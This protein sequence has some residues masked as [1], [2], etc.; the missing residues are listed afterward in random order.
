LTDG[1]LLIA[2]GVARD[3]AALR[4]AESWN[5]RAGNL[6]PAT[7]DLATARRNH[8]AQLLADGKMLLCGGTGDAGQLLQSCDLYDPEART[9]SLIDTVP[10]ESPG[11]EEG[12]H[13]VASIPDDGATNVATDGQIALRFSQPLNVATV[14]PK[15]VTLQGPESSLT[16]KAIPAEGGMLAFVS[17]K[18]SLLP[19]T[20]YVLSLDGL[21]DAA[22]RSLPSTQI[23][24]RTAGPAMPIPPDN[25][26]WVPDG[27]SRTGR[28]DSPWE[29]LPPLKAPAGTTAIAGRALKLNG[30][31]LPDV[32]LELDQSAYSTR[33]DS[34]GRFLLTVGVGVSG[35]CVL[36]IQGATANRPGKTY[37]LFQYGV[38][39][40]AGITTVLP[41]TIWMPLLDT[42]HA[43][44]IPSPT[45]K[46]TTISTPLLPGLALR[47]PPGTVVYDHDG[48]VARTI[49]ITPIPLDRPP[50]PLPNVPVPIYFTIQPGGAQLK[51]LNPKGPQGAQ[52]VYPNTYNSPVGTVYQFWNYEADG[53]GWYTYGLGKVS[54]DRRSIVPDPG[55]LIYEFTGAMV[56]DAGVPANGPAAGN[57]N[58][59]CCEPV[60]L[61][62]GLF[63][64]TKTD[65]ALPDIIP[66]VLTRTY[67]PNDPTTRAFGVGATHPYDIFLS[68]PNSDKDIYLILPDGGRIHFSNGTCTS[69]PT[70]FYGATVTDLGY[71]WVVKKKDGTTLTFPISAGASTPQQEAI[72]GYQDRYGNSLRF[73]RDSNSNLIGITSPNGRFIE[74]TLDSSGRIT[75][76]KDNIGRTV[77]Y[78]YDSCAAGL[79]CS[80]TDA[81][82]GV[83]SYTYD[84]SGNM[85]TITDPRGITYLTNQYDSNNRVIKQTQA[86]NS[87][88]QLSYTLD[89]NNN[90]TQAT[91]TDP[92]G[93]KRTT[94]FDS[95]GYT[96]SD[97]LAVGTAQ[98]EL[99]TFTRSSTTE[100]ISDVIDP[101][102]RDTHYVYD[103]LGNLSSITQLYNTSGAVTTSFTYDPTFNQVTS[104]TDP[105]NHVS[106]FSYDSL[107]N[108]VTL[109]DPLNHKWTFTY[110]AQGRPLTASDPLSN[111]TRFA[112]LG[113][114]LFA[115][116]DPLLRSVS[117]TRDGAGR[118]VSLQD[119][120]GAITQ[121][122][123]DPLNEVV[124]ATDPLAGTTM[125]AYDGNGNVLSLT[126]SLN[127]QT[128]YAYDNMDRPSTRTDPLNH[129]ESY[130]YDL[131]GNLLTLTDRKAQKTTLT[132][133]PLNRPI[134]AAYADRSSTTYTYDLG[135]RLT[136]AKDSVSGT[137]S[138]T[139]DNLDRLTKETTAQGSVSYTYDAASR[140]KTMTVAGQAAVNYGYDNA[141]RLRSVT[142]G[143][144]KVTLTYDNANRRTSLTLPNSVSTSYGY[145]KASELT[146]L[147]YK[148]GSTTLGNLTYTYDADGRQSSVGGSYARTNLPQAVSSAAY[149][150][151]N[152]LTQ[153]GSSSLTYD[154]DGN[155][156]NDG[157]NA[158]AWDARNQLASMNA[159]STASFQY[160]AFGRRMSKTVFGASTSFLYDGVNP[161]Q[162]LAGTV[163]TA[164]MI[165]GVAVDEIF[166][167]TD[168]AGARQFLTDALGST[169]ALTDSTGNA[170]TQYTYEPFGS[171]TVS[172]MT[173]GNSYQYTGRENDQNSLYFYR[174]RYYS[175]SVGR[176]IS[177][178][179][180]D[181]ANGSYSYTDDSPENRIDPIGLDF[182]NVDAWTQGAV[183]FS[184]GIGDSL[185]F[186]LTAPIREWTDSLWGNPSLPP[187]S[188]SVSRCSTAYKVGEYIP[189]IVSTARLAYAGALK[190]L[191]FVVRQGSDQ[192][193]HALAVSA[194]RN[195]A[196]KV[197]RINPWSTYR[198]YTEEEVLARYG[199][200]PKAIVDAATRSNPA[201]NGA[202]FGVMES[203]ASNIEMNAGRGCGCRQ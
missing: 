124:T 162:E 70:S 49:T 102:N 184:A 104:I 150:A 98:P 183:N 84:P 197:F 6:K 3:G 139:Y 4:T 189:L 80:V 83:T 142:Q 136:Q 42:G 170:Q 34:T 5:P 168:S 68:T 174:A 129:S 148:L 144:S 155:L 39:V 140:R 151:D 106:N 55:V 65:L 10:G 199:A 112:Y 190:L 59:G 126:D 145:D 143:T 176:F 29:H 11:S 18:S 37:G 160:D 110:D 185:S 137:I 135:N 66:A 116:T 157:T 9:F 32:T 7:L 146:S 93:N 107:G 1:S 8:T 123:Y 22:K 28:S 72:I 198:I 90:V 117:M 165:T 171:T 203:A 169:L 67:R 63:V 51:F 166:S 20:D 64:Y 15:T 196:K 131:D 178:D 138:H 100:L 173:S 127:H 38:N 192:L 41:F 130:T 91:V 47:L 53:Q 181:A 76:A 94:T 86:D 103:S 182:V 85:L 96:T 75:Q 73:A 14:T 120:T 186:G 128:A 152:Q 12:T 161:V 200:D 35:H 159:G 158:Y 81:K 23:S 17:P 99:T 89:N 36:V 58:N 54:P 30:E 2:G 163:P 132:Y 193:K 191:P 46:E 156:T 26:T 71:G 62:T 187:L 121:Y 88:F 43:V 16:L 33:S 27:S 167:R 153:W 201:I 24:F 13:L 180:A 19:N 101:L 141:D 118:V 95:N 44:T 50:F 25:E 45:K 133:D 109:A 92:R 108:L 60:D 125:F 21:S 97:T 31:P 149:N 179:P 114:D 111:T 134:K 195:T 78:A 82:G 115:V 61:G 188:P 175:S 119:P 194:A 87:T 105:L 69:S 40:Q 52:L 164:N 56:G 202:A 122:Q 74:F 77:S 79:L 48:H 147:T 113:S 154:L 172:G 177:E 57:N